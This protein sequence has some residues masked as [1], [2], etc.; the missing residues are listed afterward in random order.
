MV[1]AMDSPDDGWW[2]TIVT[3]RDEALLTLRY[4]DYPKQPVIV[5]HLSAVARIYPGPI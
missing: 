1:L 4:R 5:R 3:D 2:E